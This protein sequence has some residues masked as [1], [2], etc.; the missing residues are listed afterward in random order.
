[1]KTAFLKWKIGMRTKKLTTDLPL[2]LMP[3]TCGIS[4]LGENCI[5]KNY[6]I[7]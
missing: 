7:K 3:T 2:R 1:M 5:I 4:L 6:I